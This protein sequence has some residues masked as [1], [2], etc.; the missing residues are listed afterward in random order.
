[1]AKNLDVVLLTDYYGEMLTENQRK[2]IDYYYNDDLSLSEIADSEGI[3][4]QGVRHLI[5]KGE[6][7][8]FF[9]E[10]KLGL[11]EQFTELQKLAREL[12]SLSDSLRDEE[13]EK[14]RRLSEVAGKCAS[15]I[16]SKK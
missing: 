3:S 15:V 5:K 1:M 12:S 4:R 7:E 6:E 11:A 16:L 14:I 2:F 8:L 9:L 13:D 10:N